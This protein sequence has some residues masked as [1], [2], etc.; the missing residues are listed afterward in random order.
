MCMMICIL[1]SFWVLRPS[2]ASWKLFLPLAII[3]DDFSKILEIFW[4]KK[5]KQENSVF[6][7]SLQLFGTQILVRGYTNFVFFGWFLV[8]WP[9]LVRIQHPKAGQNKQQKGHH[10]LVELCT[11]I[12]SGGWW[13]KSRQH[14]YSFESKQGREGTKIGPTNLTSL[15]MCSKSCRIHVGTKKEGIQ[16][17]NFMWRHLT[18]LLSK[19]LTWI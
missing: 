15:S 3:F 14:L 7:Y 8:F 11:C 1:T 13:F 19:I 10:G 2:Q 9:A 12:I 17:I 4:L 18:I 5:T 16:I 6:I